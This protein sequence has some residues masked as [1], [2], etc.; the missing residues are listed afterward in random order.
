MS[1]AYRKLVMV[2][3]D[4]VAREESAR[5]EGFISSPIDRDFKEKITR[6]LDQTRYL[7]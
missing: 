4:F 3:K 1:L 5:M 7:Y 2:E 6:L